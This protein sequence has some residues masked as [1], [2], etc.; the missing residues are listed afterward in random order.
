MYHTIPGGN[1]G[2]GKAT[3]VDLARRGA[4]VIIACRNPHKAEKAVTDIQRQSGSSNVLYRHLE[5]SDQES[6][7]NF[8]EEFLREESRLD[9]LINNAGRWHPI[10][11]PTIC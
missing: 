7:R 3:A 5:L 9:Y 6:I 4:R 1:I 11:Y 10:I 2:I 8:A